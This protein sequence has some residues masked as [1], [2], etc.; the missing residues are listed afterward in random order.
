MA[1]F[2]GLDRVI[3]FTAKIADIENKP[4]AYSEISL[5]AS[6]NLHSV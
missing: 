1:R 4:S 5:I 2:S 6:V 3:V